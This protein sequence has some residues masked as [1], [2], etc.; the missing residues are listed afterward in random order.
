MIIMKKKK[1]KRKKK[2]PKR[3]ENVVLELDERDS[4]ILEY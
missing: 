3:N 4:T 2:I 1:E